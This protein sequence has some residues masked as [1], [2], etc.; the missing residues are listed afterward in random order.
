MSTRTRLELGIHAERRV[1]RYLLWCLC[2]DRDPS[3]P[4]ETLMDMYLDGTPRLEANGLMT[5]R[6]GSLCRDRAADV[7][8][9]QEQMQGVSRGGLEL[10]DQMQVEGSGIIGLGVNQQA[11]AADSSS[12]SRRSPHDVG[13][14]S[15][16][17]PLRLVSGRHA[18][19][20][21]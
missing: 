18:E 7:F 5:G 2:N 4:N 17:Q 11:P 15:C 1:G 9:H 19:P 8:H 3:V 10:R 20:R 6:S 12:R 13:Q 14:E 21:E 16:P